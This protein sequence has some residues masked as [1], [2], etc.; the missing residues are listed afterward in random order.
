M[1]FSAVPGLERPSELRHDAKRLYRLAS[2]ELDVGCS[3][4]GDSCGGS[5]GVS[6][7]GDEAMTRR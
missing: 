3:G 1:R 6:S 7:G 4:Y 5:T 2:G